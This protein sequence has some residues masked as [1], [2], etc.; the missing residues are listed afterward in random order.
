M[1]FSKSLTNIDLT[2]WSRDLCKAISE[3]IRR[4]L[5]KPIIKLARRNTFWGSYVKL[6]RHLFL[7]IDDI[8]FVRY[9]DSDIPNFIGNSIDQLNLLKKLQNF[10]S[11]VSLTVK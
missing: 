8:A 2:Y 6:I 4:E 10:C 5:G 11:I 7:I 9:A 3:M 1:L